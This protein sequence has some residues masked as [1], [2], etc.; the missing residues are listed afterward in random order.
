MEYNLYT[1]KKFVSSSLS[2][3]IENIITFICI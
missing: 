3:Q 1:N 2:K